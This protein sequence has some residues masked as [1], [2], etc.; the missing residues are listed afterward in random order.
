MATRELLTCGEVAKRLGVATHAVRELDYRRL[1]P[2]QTAKGK[3]Y[4]RDEVELLL[5]R[6]GVARRLGKSVA[7]VRAIEGRLL[8]PSKGPSGVRLFDAREVELLIGRPLGAFN[9]SQ[10]APRCK[11]LK[12]TE[13][14][15]ADRNEVS[16]LRRQIAQLRDEYAQLLAV[17]AALDD[18]VDLLGI[19]Q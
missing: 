14:C 13:S 11:V 12:S 17:A 2:V 3:R 16:S 10:W 1:S 19:S 6:S 9:H 7:A 5:T 8:H 15:R 4:R 18:A